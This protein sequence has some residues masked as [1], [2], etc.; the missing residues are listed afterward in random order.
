MDV[1]HFLEEV[2]VGDHVTL[3]NK[4]IGWLSDSQFPETNEKSRCRN[5]K[6]LLTCVQANPLKVVYQGDISP[7]W[8]LSILDTLYENICSRDHLHRSDE[9]VCL[10]RKSFLEQ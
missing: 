8:N 7:F 5:N 4:T 9:D 1:L 6:A 2:R 10:E 3:S